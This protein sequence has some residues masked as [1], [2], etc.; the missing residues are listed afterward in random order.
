MSR[1]AAMTWCKWIFSVISGRAGQDHGCSALT[2]CEACVLHVFALAIRRRNAEIIVFS[3]HIEKSATIDRH[4]EWFL[5]Q[6]VTD[7]LNCMKKGQSFITEWRPV[8]SGLIFVQ[9]I[10]A[11]SKSPAQKLPSEFLFLA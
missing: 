11:V 8:T 5:F 7:L 4:E 9:K 3:G 6:I 2:G 1:S 10:R